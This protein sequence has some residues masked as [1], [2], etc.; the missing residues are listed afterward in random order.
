MTRQRSRSCS[1]ACATGFRARRRFSI[2]INPELDAHGDLERY[3][4]AGITRLSIGVQSF[5][6]SEIEILGRKHTVPRKLTDVVA[7]ARAAA[8]ESISLD[9]MFA[10]PGQTPRTWRRSLEAA[11]ALAVDHISAYG[12]TVEARTPYAAWHAR[13]PSAFFDDDARSRTVC[14]GDGDADSAGYEQYEISNFARPGHRCAH[15]LQLL[16]ERRIRGARRRGCVLSRR[17]AQ[18]AYSLD[19]RVLRAL[20]ARAV[21]FRRKPSGCKVAGAPARR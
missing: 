8:I 7:Q 14:D 21:P 17:S 11:T 20:R 9:L 10:V 3:R 16:G 12:L 15:N 5:E 19:R 6:P 4:E 18:R 13:E 2:E 1:P